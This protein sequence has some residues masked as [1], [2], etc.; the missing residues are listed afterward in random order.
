[1]VIWT[2]KKTG[3][4]FSCVP[5]AILLLALG[6]S[7]LGALEGEQQARK[8][9]AENGR[10][11]ICVVLTTAQEAGSEAGISSLRQKMRAC[12]ASQDQCLKL[13]GKDGYTLR[14]RY[15]YSPVLALEIRDEKVIARLAQLAGVRRL[16]ADQQGSATLLESRQI[17]RANQ[18]QELGLVH[19]S[20]SAV[21]TNPC[22]A[23]HAAGR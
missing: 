21:V 4:I 1:M 13:L 18:A 14:Y 7:P 20:I 15:R 2:R 8:M 23:A 9:L 17:I 22:N 5:A 3:P 11:I 10:A 16:R 6:F 19:R 12:R